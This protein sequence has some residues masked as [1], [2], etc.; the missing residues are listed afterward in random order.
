MLAVGATGIVFGDIGTSPLY[1]FRESFVGAHKLPVDQY[2]VLGVLSMLL[3]A[4]IL[5]VTVKYVFLT[6]R[7]DNHGEGGIFALLGLIRQS[8]MQPAILGFVTAAALLATGLFYGDAV[9][10]PAMSVLSAVEGL[11]LISPNFDAWI[12]PITLKRVVS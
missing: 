7:A 5:V 12:I 1:A 11:S 3:W 2:H 6:M 10:T 8:V 9:I 4:L